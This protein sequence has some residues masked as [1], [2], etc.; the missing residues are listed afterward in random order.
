MNVRNIGHDLCHMQKLHVMRGS[1]CE[2]DPAYESSKKVSLI[3][4][5]PE[6]AFS[7]ILRLASFMHGKLQSLQLLC[8]RSYSIIK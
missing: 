4:I 8:Y 3:A 6:S 7:L 5:V 1:E 2:T